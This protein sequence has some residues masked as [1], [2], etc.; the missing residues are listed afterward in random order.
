MKLSVIIPT[1][2][3]KNVLIKCLNALFEQ[4]YPKSNFEIIVIDDGS[5][6]GTESV[7]KEIIKKLPVELRYFKQEN[8]G[9][10]AARNVGI[11]NAKGDIVLFIGDDIIAT[12]TLLEE[13]MKWHKSNPE[14]N[15][16]I[17]GFVTWSPE[18]EITPFMK[19]L[20]NGGPQFHF[21]QIQDKTEIDIQKYFY[22]SNI[23]LKREFL[24]DNNLLFDEDFP[25]AAYEDI[26]LGYRLKKVRMIL[27]YNKNAISYH[28]HC[29]S[30]DDACQRMIKVG[31]SAYI[32]SKKMG[33]EPKLI[34]KPSVRKLLSKVKFT[35]FYLIAK[36]YEKRRVKERIFLYIMDYY[37]L[38][39]NEAPIA[40]SSA[41][42]VAEAYGGKPNA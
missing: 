39:G 26:E 23:S 1:Y 31:E 5:T 21:W 18:I 28:Y 29:T 12:P 38:M 7:V 14:D 24:L 10:G 22:T 2:N 16:A 41:V 19:W 8:R 27:K 40:A 11:K 20:E 15:V 17:L 9:P 36:F 30:V 34:S 37:R 3:R 32:F 25:Y 4:I 6:D 42:K 33:H 35:I 13:H